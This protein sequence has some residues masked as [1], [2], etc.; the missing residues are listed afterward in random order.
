MK[1][2]CRDGVVVEL[3][4]SFVSRCRTLYSDVAE[5]EGVPLGERSDSTLQ[6]LLHLDGAAFGPATPRRADVTERHALHTMVISAAA[7]KVR[8]EQGNWDAEALAAAIEAA[9]YLG[10]EALHEALCATVAEIVSQCNTADD[11]R[12]N[13]GLPDDLTPEMATA[14]RAALASAEALPP[15]VMIESAA[16]LARLTSDSL[17]I[18]CWFIPSSSFVVRSNHQ[19]CP[20]GV[21]L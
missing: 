9:N 2:R 11:V 21:L 1:A 18:C 17:S 12:R 7:A 20:L 5:E 15:S 19:G 4:A 6:L 10:H 3:D 14:T 8:S 16:P 13:L